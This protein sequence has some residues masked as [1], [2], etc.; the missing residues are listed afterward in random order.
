[1]AEIEIELDN[2]TKS[3]LKWLCKKMQKSKNYI[4][5]KAVK[6]FLNKHSLTK[7]NCAKS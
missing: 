7:N 3:R 4:V 1:M 5:N 2:E 6:E